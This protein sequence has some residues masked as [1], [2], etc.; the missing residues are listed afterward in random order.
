MYHSISDD[1]EPGV[2]PYY[3]THT[4]PAVFRQHMQLLANH[5]CQTITLTQ[6]VTN[7]TKGP[8]DGWTTNYESTDH[9]TSDGINPVSPR[10][11]NPTIQLST[12]PFPP[13]VVITFDDGFRDFYTDAFPVL[14]EHGFTATMFLPTAFIGDTRRQFRPSTINSQLSTAIECLTWSEIRELRKSGI[15]F[16]SHTVNHPKLVELAWPDIKSEVSNSKAEIEQRL[17]EPPTAFCYPFAFSQADRA[18]GRAFRDLL[19]ETGHTCCATTELGRV[20]PGDDPFRLKRLP[21]NSLDD[22]ALFQAKLEGAY[23]WLA[24]PQSA[25]KRVKALL[26]RSHSIQPQA[27]TDKHRSTVPWTKFCQRDNHVTKQ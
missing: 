21:A 27:D 22:P 25:V 10:S 4:S 2:S 8:H 19:L 16:G 6:L 15:E 14:Q 13:L 9:R 7:L 26:R 11:K 20:R 5:G 3:Q 12:T 24:K 1:P 23:D 17:G 18:F